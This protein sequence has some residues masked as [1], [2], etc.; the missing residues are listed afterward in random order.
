MEIYHFKEK[1]RSSEEVE[2]NVR[3]PPNFVWILY[4]FNGRNFK[5][6]NN[7]ILLSNIFHIL[8]KHI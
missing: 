6:A 8:K 3:A 7:K 1:A 4:E 2:D 5:L